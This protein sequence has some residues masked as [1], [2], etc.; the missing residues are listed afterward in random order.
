MMR[1]IFLSILVFSVT[2]LIGAFAFLASCGDPVSGLCMR[3]AN[4]QNG[5][6]EGHWRFPRP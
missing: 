4:S 5:V 6:K 2:L 1:K 3:Q